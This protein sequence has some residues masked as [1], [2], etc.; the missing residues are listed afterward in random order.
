MSWGRVHRR[1]KAMVST[2]LRGRAAKPDLREREG[3]RLPGSTTLGEVMRQTEAMDEATRGESDAA[4][5][6]R[7]ITSQLDERGDA[8]F[9]YPCHRYGMAF[10]V[11]I[12][13]H[14]DDAWC[15]CQPVMV[16]CASGAMHSHPEHK[17]L[18]G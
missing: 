4:Q 1:T 14:T 3:E 10:I 13:N 18:M 16:P 9:R 15:W 11:M 5:V 6:M 7:S 17:E 8:D 2:L 12:G